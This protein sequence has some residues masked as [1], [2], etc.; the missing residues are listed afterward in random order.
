M[1]PTDNHEIHPARVRIAQGDQ[2]TLRWCAVLVL[3]ICSGILGLAFWLKP[4]PRG[5]GTHEQFGT[6]PCGMVLVT[7]YP[8]PTC[9]M[10]T[11]FAYTVRGRW[12]RAFMAQ[13]AGFVLALVTI[14]AMVG[15]LWVLITGRWPVRLAFILT[16][17]RL[18]LG[19]L[20]LLLGGWAF[21]LVVGLMNGT[22]PVR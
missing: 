11:A 21:K 5:F 4:D 3:V 16:P 1:T 12:L 8:C 2:R 13:P 7:G 19:L 9:G 20:V 6:G 14:A 17:Y 15:S 22:L 18:F 10:T